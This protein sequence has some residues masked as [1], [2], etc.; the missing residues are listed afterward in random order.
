MLLYA[1]MYFCILWRRKGGSQE[2]LHVSSSKTRITLQPQRKRQW[3]IFPDKNVYDTTNIPTDVEK[4]KPAPR[5]LTG[6]TA[7]FQYRDHFQ[8][9]EQQILN[10]MTG[11]EAQLSL[12]TGWEAQ[13]SPLSS[14]FTVSRKMAARVSRKLRWH[15]TTARGNLPISTHSMGMHSQ[16]IWQMMQE[17]GNSRLKRTSHPSVPDLL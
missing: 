10:I 12:M 11:W 5:L 13:L 14:H 4:R 2:Y 7:C 15:W 16:S 6:A 3:K 9:P 17:S 1:K 8:A